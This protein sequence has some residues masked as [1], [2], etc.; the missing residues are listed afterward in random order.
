MHTRTAAHSSGQ[1]LPK[2]NAVRHSCLGTF[3]FHDHPF[4]LDKVFLSTIHHG[5]LVVSIIAWK[6][7]ECWRAP[8][9]KFQNFLTAGIN[10]PNSSRN[11]T[12][13]ECQC[14]VCK[15]C[16]SG[17]PI[18]PQPK[19]FFLHFQTKVFPLRST[20]HLC[21]GTFINYDYKDYLLLSIRFWCL[22]GFPT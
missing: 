15:A 8:R 13:Q 19:C 17:H 18:P 1:S 7:P 16:F 2:S 11:L 9:I 22:K 3:Q 10:K 12:M 4:S 20:S 14:R 6:S 5:S 21:T